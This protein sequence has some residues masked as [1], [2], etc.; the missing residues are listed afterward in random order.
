VPQGKI[1]PVEQPCPT[2]GKPQIKIIQFRQKPLTRCVDPA[3]PSNQEPEIPLGPCPVCAAAGRGSAPTAAP[4]AAS[5]DAAPAAAARPGTII[6]QRSP[7]TLKRFA[8]CTNYEEC[9]TSYPLPQRGELKPTNTSCEACGA[10]KVTIATR[11]GPWEICPNPQCSINIA[12][13]EE[14]AAKAA[15]GGKAASSGKAAG[16]KTAGRKT[17][18]KKTA[19][20]KTASNKSALV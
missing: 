9:K 6:A 14:K 5:R 11:R 13:A 18:S 19:G 12:A 8:R 7:R 17:A 3:C 20:R 15:G 2:C 16:V 4:A 10:P 1:E